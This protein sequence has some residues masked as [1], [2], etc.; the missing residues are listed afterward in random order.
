MIAFIMKLLSVHSVPLLVP[1][2]IV[3]VCVKT[4]WQTSLL[5]NVGKQVQKCLIHQFLFVCQYISRIL[6]GL[7]FLL[8][9]LSQ[10]VLSA[11]WII[12]KACQTGP[13]TDII[14]FCTC[15]SLLYSKK[16]SCLVPALIL[17]SYKRSLHLTSIADW[18]NQDLFH[19]MTSKK[20]QV[21]ED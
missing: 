7:G 21:I 4:G 5:K 1:T 6:I 8:N 18:S 20:Y 2:Y 11:M 19:L 13:T 15:S 12:Q 3:S 10:I 14:V 16:S 17:L 9:S